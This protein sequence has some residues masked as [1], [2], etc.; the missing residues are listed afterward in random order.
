MSLGDAR[1]RLGW[2]QSELDR[3]AGVRQGTVSDIEL[4]RN[5]RP[6]YE[7]VMQIVKDVFPVPAA[8]AKAS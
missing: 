8:T 1:G 2:S 7:T 3:R 5:E 4:G 6:A